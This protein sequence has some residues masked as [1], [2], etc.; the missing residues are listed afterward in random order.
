M[1]IA[2]QQIR[3]GD[4]RW[5]WNE[6]FVRVGVGLVLGLVGAAYTIEAW[7]LGI[8]STGSP[9]PGLFPAVVGLLLTVSAFVTCAEEWRHRSAA[10][11][12]DVV[13][14]TGDADDFAVVG[15][16]F[17]GAAPFA[18]LVT[19][20]AAMIVYVVGTGWV[21]HLITASVVTAVTTRILGARSWW[22]CCVVGLASGGLTFL[23]FDW[24]LDVPL[25]LGY[26]GPRI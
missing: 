19:V 16:A 1:T 2:D 4:T 20:V 8:G 22:V 10:A 21:G 23:V 6:P 13:A 5:G 26:F 12:E 25:P 7:R 17:G 18:R 11:D 9:G 3:G 24:L 14:T 15:E